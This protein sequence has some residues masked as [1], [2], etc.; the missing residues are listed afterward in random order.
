MHAIVG[1]NVT[2]LVSRGLKAHC[3]KSILGPWSFS[4][5]I[6]WTEN[7]MQAENLCIMMYRNYCI[8]DDLKG[9]ERPAGTE[10]ECLHWQFDIWIQYKQIHTWQFVSNIA[11]SILLVLQVN[12]RNTGKY[13]QICM[14]TN[15][16]Y[17]Y[18]HCTQMHKDT[19]E[20]KSI[21]ANIS[22]S[23]LIQSH[24]NTL[25][26]YRYKRIYMNTRQ[27]TRANIS[28]SVLLVLLVNLH[29]TRKYSQLCS[30]ANSTYQYM[31]YIQIHNKSWYIQILQIMSIAAYIHAL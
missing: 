19:H 14:D 10:L 26:T 9:F 1:A 24:T 28:T 13:S 16:K 25:N 11:I 21:Q 20:Y 3:S 17:Q 22:I 2:R 27:R 18:F 7:Q 23:I 31:Q 4:L 5:T 6:L 12:S 15:S 8:K 30:Y 29:N